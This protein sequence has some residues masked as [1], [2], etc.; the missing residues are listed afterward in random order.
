MLIAVNYHSSKRSAR[1]RR[2]FELFGLASRKV[3]E[4][5]LPEHRSTLFWFDGGS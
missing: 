1:I 4:G 5:R 3:A 2:N